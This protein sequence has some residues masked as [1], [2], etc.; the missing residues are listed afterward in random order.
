MCSLHN[1]LFSGPHQD[2]LIDELA[3][4]IHAICPEN[5]HTAIFDSRGGVPQ[6]RPQ[7]D[8]IA[9]FFQQVALRGDAPSKTFAVLSALYI[10]PHIMQG[11]RAATPVALSQAYLENFA[12]RFEKHLCGTATRANKLPI[13]IVLHEWQLYAKLVTRPGI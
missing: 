3:S 8:R 5:C 13:E 4:H 10:A 9:G 2:R 6:P 11:V 7:K 12:D 1:A